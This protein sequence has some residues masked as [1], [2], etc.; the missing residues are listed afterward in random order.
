MVDFRNQGVLAKRNVDD[1]DDRLSSYRVA[2][3]VKQTNF[4]NIYRRINTELTILNEQNNVGDTMREKVTNQI[5]Q[6]SKVILGERVALGKKKT[7]DTVRLKVENG[8]DS[9]NLRAGCHSKPE[10]GELNW[11]KCRRYNRVRIVGNQ[12]I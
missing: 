9:R 4:G 1:L 2:N 10:N 6:L 3:A 12:P 8:V 5:G 11:G 7:M